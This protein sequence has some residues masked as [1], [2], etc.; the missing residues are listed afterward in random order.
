MGS[1]NKFYI[2]QRGEFAR[3]FE[4]SYSVSGRVNYHST[5]LVQS[6]VVEGP[7]YVTRGV[8]Q[9][10]KLK[11]KIFKQSKVTKGIRFAKVHI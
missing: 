11:C 2:T 6:C 1:L 9:L 8:N 10:T 7:N 5:F 3:G 4:L